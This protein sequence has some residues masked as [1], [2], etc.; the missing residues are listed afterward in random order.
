MAPLSA[1]G[2]LTTWSK[3]LLRQQH[4]PTQSLAS[5]GRVQ[6]VFMSLTIHAKMLRCGWF[7]RPVFLLHLNQ[8]H[9]FAARAL[10]TA[11]PLT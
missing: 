2:L 9:R 7:C 4:L 10:A 11:L 3:K 6:K 8:L 5:L 1:L